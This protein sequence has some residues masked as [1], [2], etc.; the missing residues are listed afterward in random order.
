M[1]RGGRGGGGMGEQ[2]R[3]GGGRA[4][5]RE[6]GKWESRKEWGGGE[7][8]NGRAE[9]SGE[10]GRGEMGEQKGVGRG[11]EGNGR[12]ER[13]GEENGRLLINYLIMTC[14]SFVPCISFYISAFHSDI[15]LLP[16]NC[17]GNQRK[18][19]LWHQLPQ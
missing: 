9:R 17:Q 19:W 6:G 11:G 7:G 5:R 15:M 18:P 4:E 3:G 16:S 14:K 12:T 13:R 8:G 10:G 1:R 2:K